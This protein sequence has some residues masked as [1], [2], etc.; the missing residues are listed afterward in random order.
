MYKVEYEF[1][2]KLIKSTVVS[3][4]LLRL[5]V[6]AKTR[7]SQFRATLDELPLVVREL[8][9]E[10]F[11]RLG[12]MSEVCEAWCGWSARS[13]S[14]NWYGNLEVKLTDRIGVLSNRESSEIV[15]QPT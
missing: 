3:L 4:R 5:V 11:D 6:E 1:S 9:C 14:A 10:M 2:P 13:R 12:V 8:W 15:S 7:N